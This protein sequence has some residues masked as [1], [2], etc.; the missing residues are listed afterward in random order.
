MMAEALEEI[1]V[2]KRQRYEDWRHRHLSTPFLTRIQR[3]LLRFL[4]ASVVPAGAIAFAA[5]HN[6]DRTKMSDAIKDG[7]SS[8]RKKVCGDVNCCTIYLL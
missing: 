1:V 8:L 5:H 4:V 2:A 6:F 7:G 3:R